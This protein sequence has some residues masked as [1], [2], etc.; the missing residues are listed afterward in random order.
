MAILIAITLSIHPLVRLFVCSHFCNRYLSF[1]WKKWF[2]IWYVALAWWLVPCLL[3]PGLP[4]IYFLFTVRLTNERVEIFLARC[5]VQH[6]VC[7]VL[8]MRKSNKSSIWIPLFDER[9]RE[10]NI[11]IQDGLMSTIIHIFISWKMGAFLNYFLKYKKCSWRK[12]KNI[13]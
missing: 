10:K 8:Q 4:H 1:Y 9:E 11:N 12:R 5:S 6:L 13:K 3:F 7:F 2:H